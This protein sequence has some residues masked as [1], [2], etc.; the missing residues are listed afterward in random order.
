M[1][2]I[3]NNRARYRYGFNVSA[4]WKGFDLGIF[5]QG[6]GKRDIMLPNTFRWQYGSQWQ[7][8]L[9]PLTTTGAKPTPM[10]GCRLH[11]SMEVL[12]WDRTRHVTCLTLPTCV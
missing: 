10:H 1:K 6:V 8:R 3:G 9:Q 12:L 5:F 4:D 11:V 2:I 7:V